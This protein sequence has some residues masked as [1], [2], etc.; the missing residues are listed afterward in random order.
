MEGRVNMRE[1]PDEMPLNLDALDDAASFNE[2]MEKV[3]D[4]IVRL[5]DKDKDWTRLATEVSQA[6]QTKLR[7]E[8]GGS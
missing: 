6:V 5:A 8:E 1:I 7:L 2:V 4:D 3:F